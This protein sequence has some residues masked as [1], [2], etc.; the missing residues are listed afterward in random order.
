MADAVPATPTPEPS[1][2]R[3]WSVPTLRELP[4]L[5]KLTLASLIGGGGGTGGGGS[6]VFTPFLAASALAASLLTGCFADRAFDPGAGG[7]PRV[8]AKVPCVADVRA[9]QV[10]C[11]AL[12]AGAPGQEIFGGQGN[13]VALK[14]FFVTYN[15]L[16]S[17]FTFMGQVQNLTTQHIGNDGAAITGIKVFFEDP[18]TPVTITGDGG[19]IDI[20]LDSTG[21]FTEPNQ[22]YYF[23]NEE[24]YQGW[25]SSWVPWQFH[26]DPDVLTF[27][28][29]V[30]VAADV[31][32]VGGVLRWLPVENR[33]EF[34]MNGVAY[35][36][37]TDILAVGRQGMA[38]RYDGTSWSRITPPTQVNFNAVAAVGGGEYLVVGD[39]GVVFRLKNGLW[40]YVYQHSSGENLFAVTSIPGGD[41]VAVGTNGRIA[42][43]IGGA[44]SEEMP[45]PGVDLIAVA[46][47]SDGS[48]VTVLS[49]INL[50][51]QSTAGGAFAPGSAIPGGAVGVAYD[52]TDALLWAYQ[53]G[54]S[55]N[56]VIL[57]GLDTLVNDPLVLPKSLHVFAPGTFSFAA[58][59]LNDGFDYIAHGT[60]GGTPA[61]AYVSDPLGYGIKEFAPLAAGFTRWLATENT[62]SYNSLLAMDGGWIFV[63]YAPQGTDPDIW[64]IGN[65]VWY[66]DGT[67]AIAK[68]ENGAVT[69]LNPLPGAHNI[70]V[71]NAGEIYVEDG[72]AVYK[73]DGVGAWTLEVGTAGLPVS[74]IWGDAASGNMLVTL[75]TGDLLIKQGGSWTPISLGGMTLTGVWGC[76]PT[77][78]WI[79][80]S[81]G[82][83][84]RWNGGPGVTLD[85]DFFGVYGAMAPLN[86]I[87]GTSCSDVWVGGPVGAV[88]WDG[89]DWTLVTTGMPVL[90]V[91]PRSPGRAYL[92]HG[93]ASNFEVIADS[94]G[95]KSY[96][97]LQTQNRLV[98]AAWRLTNG[99]LI[100]AGERY[101]LRGV[102]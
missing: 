61:W 39:G 8:I 50:L 21:T 63:Q 62:S 97:Q 3:R 4:K 43:S 54:P 18:P 37:D 92:L 33:T 10:T 60:W 71:R 80:T 26:I 83:V 27:S 64:G 6:T 65:I 79:T 9:Q 100:V 102:R 45:L 46:S 78:A 17:L 57:R 70:W 32:D 7:M 67:G 94:A 49:S 66:V 69:E 55:G 47:N 5:T 58:T 38:L 28:F 30:L 51:L 95:N 34:S 72:N 89:N 56:G 22:S 11:A 19:A 93:Q 76:G 2:P 41:W 59:N 90:A 82:E 75:L 12:P 14:A 23:Y 1:Q 52:E 16:D 13:K 44:I 81:Q 99:E 20:Q 42:R 88:H 24:L 73:G 96:F 36:S 15:P 74:D 87:T 48:E 86:A 29:S 31:E 85:T 35:T 25:W 98:M 91:A 68:I 77:Q 53:D 101:V 40:E 84:F